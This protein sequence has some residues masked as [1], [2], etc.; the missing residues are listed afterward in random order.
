MATERSL[1]DEISAALRSG[2]LGED[3]AEALFYRT[4]W[5]RVAGQFPER[6][7]YVEE[8]RS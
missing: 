4:L 3:Q 5:Q 6:L 8:R 1:I 7:R 2:H